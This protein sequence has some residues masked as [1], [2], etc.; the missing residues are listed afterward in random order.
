MVFRK[1]LIEDITSNIQILENCECV[2]LLFSLN[3]IEDISDYVFLSNQ[4][5][6]AK[7]SFKVSLKDYSVKVGPKLNEGFVVRTIFHS[8]TS[9]FGRPSL[10]DVDQM[11]DSNLPWV[12]FY[13]NKEEIRFKVY[14]FLNDKIETVKVIFTRD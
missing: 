14:Q 2:G 4:S 8:H 1:S 10:L 6:A 5:S 12:I 7:D 13:R 3:G 9:S 11:R